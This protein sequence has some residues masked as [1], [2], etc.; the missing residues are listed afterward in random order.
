MVVFFV[1]LAL[2]LIII[3]GTFAYHRIIHYQRLA[4]NSW[5]DIAAHLR[6]R[7]DLIP[8]LVRVARTVA[9]QAESVFNAIDGARTR[10]AEAPGPSEIAEA[11]AVLQQTL[12]SLFQLVEEKP[13]LSADTE[14]ARLQKELADA[15][16]EIQLQR[17]FYN[18]VVRELNEV[19]STFP[20]S[21]VAAVF[22]LGARDFFATE[23]QLRSEIRMVIV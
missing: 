21:M 13:K 5:E 11:E 23:E 22:G 7:W 10:A 4:D 1:G 14:F 2:L 3:W 17:K 8:D 15:E 6:R 20:R 9:P 12:F 18:V 16:D 19:V